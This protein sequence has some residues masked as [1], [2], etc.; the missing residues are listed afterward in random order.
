MAKGTVVYGQGRGKLGGMVLRVVEGKQVF[1]SYQPVVKN[2][3][4][5][6]QKCQRTAM[7]RAG[8]L[9]S[10]C[11]AAIK[12]GYNETY[13]AAAFIKKAIGRNGGFISVSPLEPDNATVN[14]SSV[15]LSK[16]D[17]AALAVVLAGV[18][19]YGSD[20]H[21][22]VKATSLQV[23]LA[24][25]VDTS[26]V[27][28]YLAVYTPDLDMCV[29]SEPVAYAD[30]ASGVSVNVPSAWD[31]MTVHAYMFLTIAENTADV[32]AYDQTT[33]RLPY[34]T[35]DTNYLGTGEIE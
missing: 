35:S 4:T 19:D 15:K 22:R 12:L 2:P 24:P 10:A 3:S 7:S 34:K 1:Q 31:G 18:V 16:G 14:Y 29:I 28:A 23:S 21:L 6:P 30:I 9:A 17:G 8:K 25:Q 13:A 32:D 33:T 26:N 5:L 20:Q 11:L 27:K